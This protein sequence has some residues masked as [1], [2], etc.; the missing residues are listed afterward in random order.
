MAIIPSRG[1]TLFIALIFMVVLT[2]IGTVLASF[3]FKQ[4][5]LASSATQSQYSFYAADSALECA[6]NQDQNLSPGA[7]DYSSS[8]TTIICGN[9]QPMSGV[10]NIVEVCK[11]GAGTKTDCGANYRETQVS[12]ISLDNGQ[13]CADLTVYKPQGLGKTYIFAQG[14]NLPCAQVNTN[15]A[16]VARGLQAT[17]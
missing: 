5:Q 3:I 9:D 7:F 6:L 12:N 4:T 11:N 13:H 10:F 16:T 2:A 15:P 1:F 8:V 14:Y 17:Y